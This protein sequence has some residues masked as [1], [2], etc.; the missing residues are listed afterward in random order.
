LKKKSAIELGVQGMRWR[1]FGNYL[2]SYQRP[3]LQQISIEAYMPNDKSLFH[4]GKTYSRL[5]DPLMA[6]SHAQIVSR[7]PEGASVL[8]IGCGTGVLCFKLHQKK[9]C[10][11]LGVD[12]SLRMLEFAQAHNRFTEVRFLHQDATE[13]VDIADESFDLAILCYII[14]ELQRPSQINLLREAWRV[15]RSLIL[16][17][18]YAPL[19]WNLVGLIKRLTECGF[20]WE[21]SPQFRNFLAGGGIPSLLAEAGLAEHIA[22]RDQ[23]QGG[24]NH[25][26]VVSR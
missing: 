6:E 26:V 22:N 1:E 13:M 16:V 11:V 2:F 5:I 3:G 23:F 15:A 17:D 10:R 21:H 18:S 19:P 9:G 8:D 24:C 7:T 12:L 14:H 25:V 4:Y 20:G